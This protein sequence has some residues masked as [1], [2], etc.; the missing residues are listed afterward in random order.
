ME[1]VIYDEWLDVFLVVIQNANFTCNHVRRHHIVARHHH[2]ANIGLSKLANDA[3][4]IITRV[5]LE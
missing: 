4:A 1:T 5:V 2:T 3:F